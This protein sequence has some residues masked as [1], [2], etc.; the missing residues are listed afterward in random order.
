MAIRKTGI[1]SD[2]TDWLDKLDA[3]H[4]FYKY[5]DRIYNSYNIGKG[6]RDP[7]QFCDVATDFG[8]QPSAILFV[9]DNEMNAANALASRMQAILY[10]DHQSFIKSLNDALT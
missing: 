8:L 4:H 6:K 9:D 7:S 5:F 10:V 2:Q 1:L 3:Q